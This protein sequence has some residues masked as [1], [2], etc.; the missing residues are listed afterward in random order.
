MKRGNIYLGNFTKKPPQAH[1]ALVIDSS[2]RNPVLGNPYP[3]K[4]KSAQE[5]E[6]VCE[7]YQKYFDKEFAKGEDLWRTCYRIAKRVINGKDVILMCWCEPERCHTR[8][9]RAGILQLVKKYAA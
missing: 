3:M 7:E 6:R 9:I 1:E 5:R 2:R 4:N 8:T